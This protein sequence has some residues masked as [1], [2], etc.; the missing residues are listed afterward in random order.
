MLALVNDTPVSSEKYEYAR[1]LVDKIIIQNITHG[2]PT[3]WDTNKVALQAAFS[4][5]VELLSLSLE[6]QQQQEVKG[7]SWSWY[8]ARSVFSRGHVRN[9]PN[10]DLSPFSIEKMCLYICNLLFPMAAL[11]RMS[12]ELPPLMSASSG[13]SIS[14]VA[15]KLSQELVWITEKFKECSSIYEASRMWSIESRLSKLSLSAHPRVQASL[16]R[17]S[18]IYLY[19]S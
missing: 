8:L 6:L 3:L 10:N 19:V 1:S 5:T 17:V 18:G 13:S 15:E 9:S 11:T 7:N 16:L 12:S 14:A 2:D 4:R